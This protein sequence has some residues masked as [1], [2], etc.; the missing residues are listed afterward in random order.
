[1]K[2]SIGQLAAGTGETVKTLRY[3]T[4]QGLLAAERGPNGYRYYQPAMI[5]RASLIRS[6]QALGFSLGEIAE[7]VSLRD[8]GL[9]PCAEVR[10]RL[11]A[12]LHRVV[13]RI[14]DLRRLETELE[15]RLSWAESHPEPECDGDGCV[16]LAAEGPSAAPW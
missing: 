12:Q 10:E 5:E 8:S 6:V 11:G 15:A 1:M 7:I 4:E 16:Y 9:Q 3:W 2:L 13:Q 14:A